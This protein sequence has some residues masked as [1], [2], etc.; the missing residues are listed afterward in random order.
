MTPSVFYAACLALW[1][2][3][4]RVHAVDELHVSERTIRKWIAGDD[5]VNLG[6]R[7]DLHDRLTRKLGEIE[8]IRAA[9][10]LRPVAS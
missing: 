6:V 1:G 7:A 5:Q 9:I 3:S 2:S 8:A 4:W 10:V